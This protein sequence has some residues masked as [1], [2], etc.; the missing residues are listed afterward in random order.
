MSNHKGK[1]IE[2]NQKTSLKMAVSTYLLTATLNV[3]ELNIPVKD[4]WMDLK[5]KKTHICAV[6]RSLTSDLTAHIDW[7]WGDG[8]RYSMQMEIKEKWGSNNHTRQTTL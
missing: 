6:W 8:Q 5:K 3:N 4:S 2:N 1:E 7:K